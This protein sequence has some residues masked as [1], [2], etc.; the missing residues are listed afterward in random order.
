MMSGTVEP[1]VTM[2]LMLGIL[3]VF[4]GISVAVNLNVPVRLSRRWK[5]AVSM[6][7]AAASLPFVVY[8]MWGMISPFIETFGGKI[9]LPGLVFIGGSLYLL[10]LLFSPVL[11]RGLRSYRSQLVRAAEAE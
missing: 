9:L 7:C 6:I 1:L 10:F 4:V 2:F 8:G 11:R 3:Y 5:K